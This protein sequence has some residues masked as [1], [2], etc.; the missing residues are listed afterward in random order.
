MLAM[1]PTQPLKAVIFD[2]D[3]T[4][5]NTEEL[6]WDCG[7]TML[8]RRGHQVTREL[9]DQMM[10]R[11]SRVALQI[12]IDWHQLDAT[13]PELQAETTEIFATLLETRLA[14]M[15]GVLELLDVLEA[16]GLPRAIATSS[17]RRFLDDVLVRLDMKSRF[18]PTFTADDVNEGKPH[19]EI[20]LKTAERLGLS[21]AQT[22]VL[23]DSA[24][25]CRA[26]VDAGAYTIAVPGEHSRQHNFTGVAFIADGLRDARIYQALGLSR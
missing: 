16:A 20:Y 25:G 22:L 9:L 26:A 12:M 1:L 8:R 18:N 13:V 3:G 24:N 10:G 2:L 21:P 23:E 14:L 4:L 7:D 6:Y 17:S 11:P 5:L 15:P 19:P